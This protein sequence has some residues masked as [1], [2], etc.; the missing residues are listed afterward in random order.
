MSQ[1]NHSPILKH[2][3]SLAAYPRDCY[4]CRRGCAF[5]RPARP[6]YRAREN[7]G[8]RKRNWSG[9]VKKGEPRSLG[10][11]TEAARRRGACAAAVGPARRSDGL[12]ESGRIVATSAPRGWLV[13]EPLAR[14]AGDIAADMRTGPAYPRPGLLKFSS[15]WARRPR[16][17]CQPPGGPL[18]AA[19]TPTR[20]RRGDND[21]LVIARRARARARRAYHRFFPSAGRKGAASPE[22]VATAGRRSSRRIARACAA[23]VSWSEIFILNDFVGE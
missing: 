10:A 19:V 20:R 17:E 8:Q 5:A 14:H 16:P 1:L 18:P 12:S 4:Y 21:T 22:C 15:Q 6:R 23:A 7:G 11:A 2:E 3:N 9:A 13:T